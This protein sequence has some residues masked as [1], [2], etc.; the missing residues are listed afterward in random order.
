MRKED[1]ILRGRTYLQKRETD[2]S[3]EVKE[4][5]EDFRAE[6]SSSINSLKT[7]ST[8]E[9]VFNYEEQANENIIRSTH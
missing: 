8:K 1:I 9:P 5:D 2:R 6:V 3:D 7:K 4:E